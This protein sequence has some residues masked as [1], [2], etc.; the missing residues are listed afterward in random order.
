[1][2]L[3][4]WPSANL[5]GAALS[6]QHV[7]GHM[8][9]ANLTGANLTSE[10]SRSKYV[11]CG[12]YRPRSSDA[13]ERLDTR[14]SEPRVNCW[15][16]VLL[17]IGSS[18]RISR[19]QQRKSESADFTN[20]NLFGLTWLAQFERCSV[21]RCFIGSVQGQFSVTLPSGW[22]I[23]NGYLFGPG[24]TWPSES[25]GVEAFCDLQGAT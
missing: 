11:E 16:T 22:S 8:Q 25:A 20:A 9:G 10:T 23:Q 14:R 5:T 1:V 19:R 6:V 17:Q 12:S 4:G 2:W 18:E 3:P 24:R 7:V 15:H 13:D 21:D